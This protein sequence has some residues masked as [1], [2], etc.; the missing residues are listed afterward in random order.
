MEYI[1]R[2]CP[3]CKKELQVPSDLQ[4]CICM[5]CGESFELQTIA[6][7]IAAA[8]ENQLI[9]SEEIETAY[10]S[11]LTELPLLIEDYDRRL[12]LFTWDKYAG[13]FDE[14]EQLGRKILKSAETLMASTQSDQ[15]A[16]MK[17]LAN[18]LVEAMEQRMDPKIRKTMPKATVIDQLRFFQAVYLIPMIRHLEFGLSEALAAELMQE[19]HKRYP[20]YPYQKSDYNKIVEGFQRKGLCFITSAVCETLQKPDDC[21]ELTAFRRFR[22]TYMLESEDR[23][24]KVEEYYRIAPVIVNSIQMN[25]DADQRYQAIWTEYLQPCLAALEEGRMEACENLYTG[26]VYTMKSQYYFVPS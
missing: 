26:M 22:D 16:L 21:Y 5:Y 6:E 3:S 18:L 15:Q 4:K 7:H 1:T 2:Y 8:E 25:P 11:A 10:R 24:S 9:S 19:W 13:C 14:L 23:R 20:K 12:V 17:E